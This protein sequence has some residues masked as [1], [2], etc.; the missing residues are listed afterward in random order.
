MSRLS[1]SAL[2]H[3]KGHAWLALPARLYLATVFLLACFHKIAHPD[4]FAVDVATYQFLPLVTVN[5]FAIVLPWVELGAGILLIV[6]WK[7]RAASAL[8]AMMMLAFIIALA[9]ALS[10][11][12]DMSCGCFASNAVANEDPISGWTVLRDTAWLLLAL[13]VMVFDRE[14]LGLERL[15]RVRDGGQ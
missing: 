1:W 6:G 4:Q 2:L 14:P 10:R 5:L 12:L 15:R 8:V 7:S 3:W 11:G 13:Y 9:S